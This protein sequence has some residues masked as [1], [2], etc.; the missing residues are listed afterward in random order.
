M[1]SQVRLVARVATFVLVLASC[2]CSRPV[3]GTSVHGFVHVG[4]IP[5]AEG[6][7]TF[8]PLPGTDGPKISAS[9]DQGVYQING[10][11]G[12]GN[13]SFRVEVFGLPPAVKAMAQGQ[14][15]S[16]GPNDYR[17]IDDRFNT[18]S[19]LLCEILPDQDQAHDFIVEYANERRP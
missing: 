14:P 4:K 6:L 3:I 19:E 1:V 7:I 8:V 18:Q 9:I 12:L 11:R 5:L 16:H 13:G 17:E 15:V 10:D 2:G